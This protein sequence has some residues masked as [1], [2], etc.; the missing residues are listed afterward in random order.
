MIVTAASPRFATPRRTGTLALVTAV[1]ALLI[2]G[3]LQ[4]AHRP[5][6]IVA[7]APVLVGVAVVASRAEVDTA[8][9]TVP[10]IVTTAHVVVPEVQV[11]IAETTATPAPPVAASP[12]L[13]P[14]AAAT[15]A[16]ATAMHAITLI[17]TEAI[18]YRVPPP[19]EYPRASR[20]LRECGRVIVRVL[21]DTDGMPREAVVSTSSGYARLDAAAL[22]AVQR[23]RFKPYIENGV[24][25]PGWALIPLDF[26][27]DA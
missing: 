8:Q 5:P 23:A 4:F 2:V 26:K 19:L 1:H 25:S 18:A 22:S 14:V 13:V 16:P 6:R 21:V 27:L 9:V 17:P 24:P 10:T 11:V 20:K 3:L 15:N 7:D 12:A